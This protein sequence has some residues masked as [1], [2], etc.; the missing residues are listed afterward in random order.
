MKAFFGRG[1]EDSG[2][3]QTMHSSGAYT[4]N[5]YLQSWIF[6]G[7]SDDFKI[8]IFVYHPIPNIDEIS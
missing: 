6:S 1:N 4:N 7:P 8:W 3:C 2:Y 5:L